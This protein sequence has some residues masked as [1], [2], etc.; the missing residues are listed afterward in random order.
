LENAP[1]RFT[2]WLRVGM[3]ESLQTFS[4]RN[5]ELSPERVSTML[6]HCVPG[7]MPVFTKV[8]SASPR[9]IAV[10]LGVTFASAWLP[11]S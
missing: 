4:E 9:P 7:V 10:H 2:I 8:H 5:I 6:T 11:Q 3:I 1:L